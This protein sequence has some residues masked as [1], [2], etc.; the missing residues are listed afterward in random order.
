MLKEYCDMKEEVK[1][2]QQKKTSTVNQIFNI[3]IKQFDL[4]V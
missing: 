4:I 1:N 3:I 2:L